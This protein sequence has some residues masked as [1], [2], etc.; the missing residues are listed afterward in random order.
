ML[1]EEFD[2]IAAGAASKTLINL[3]AGCNRERGGFL[4]VKR[5]Q[6]KVIGSPFLQFHEIT[7]NLHNINAGKDLLYG[8]LRNQYY[9]AGLNANLIN[10]EGIEE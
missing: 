8:L 1:H 3:L 7:Y 6:T 9:S 2:G 10:F 4:V 5:A